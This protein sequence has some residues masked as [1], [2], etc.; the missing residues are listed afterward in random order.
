[1]GRALRHCSNERSHYQNSLER[2]SE[3][4]IQRKIGR[5]IGKDNI[6]TEGR[7][8]GG[9][10]GENRNTDEH[11][12]THTNMLIQVSYTTV[13]TAQQQ[14]PPTR[15]IFVE[16]TSCHGNHALLQTSQNSIS[17]CTTCGGRSIPV[18][19]MVDAHPQCSIYS[20]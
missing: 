12:R 14:A 2:E 4:G 20:M 8:E 19:T 18:Y 10:E 11:A 9:R 13:K 15:Q 6:H 7:R 3:R 16:V 17:R 1:M 5:G